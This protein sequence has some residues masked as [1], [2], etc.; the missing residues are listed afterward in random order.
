ML[1]CISFSI[2]LKKASQ[3][4]KTG[5]I[6]QPYN[7]RILYRLAAILF[8]QRNEVQGQYYLETALQR[9]FEGHTEF[10]EVLPWC[11]RKYAHH[12]YDTNSRTQKHVT[13]S[14]C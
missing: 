12:G 1:T 7:S 4:L 14:T 5:L 11:S 13:K 10:L 3:V 2:S 8:R 9:D 6:H